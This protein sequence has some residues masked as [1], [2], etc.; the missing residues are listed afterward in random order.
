MP[1]PEGNDI[2][3]RIDQLQRVMNRLAESIGQ[4]L[5]EVN[6]E[7]ATKQSFVLPFFKELGYNVHS[8]KEFKPEITSS[9]LPANERVDYALFK[10]KLLLG[11]VECKHWDTNLHGKKNWQQLFKYN[12]AFVESKFAIMTNG[13]EYMFYSDFE[14]ENVLDQKP[15]FVFNINSFS[16]SDLR[17]LLKFSRD[18]FSK[19]SYLL[20]KCQVLLNKLI[21]ARILIPAKEYC[22]FIYNKMLRMSGTPPAGF[23]EILHDCMISSTPNDAAV[24]SLAN[25]LVLTV[26]PKT[27]RGKDEAVSNEFPHKIGIVV[28][29]AF[30]RAFEKNLFS[31]DD[32][33]FLLSQKSAV[34]FKTAGYIFLRPHTGEKSDITGQDGRVRYY[35]EP[36]ICRKKKYYITHELYKRGLEPILQYLEERSMS[37]EEVAAICSRK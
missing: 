18:D 35:A 6:S 24:P 17:T 13:I 4:N 27:F 30:R 20:L 26:S 7:E 15:F 36:V 16:R 3:N 28:N 11:I 25:S 14:Q 1:H 9:N 12:A 31:E 37:R 23:S 2:E 29:K 19:E 32:V 33:K 21:P 8:P 10:D 22:R 34:A 5:T